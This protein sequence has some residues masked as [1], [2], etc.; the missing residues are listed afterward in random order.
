MKGPPASPTPLVNVTVVRARHSV[1]PASATAHES[2]SGFRNA[3]GR[4]HLPHH[5][6]LR[7]LSLPLEALAVQVG[8]REFVTVAADVNHVSGVA[9]EF[10][11]ALLAR[12]G[13]ADDVVWVEHPAVAADSALPTRS[14]HA[15]PRAA[16]VFNP[17]QGALVQTS[18]G[19]VSLSSAEE[20]YD[21]D[22]T[23]SYRLTEGRLI[24]YPLICR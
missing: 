14:G 13:L 20:P 18:T 10:G 6:L 7:P 17:L 4:L 1:Q 11:S 8:R 23:H 21:S 19:S 5:L 3:S 9:D 22:M 24:R 15:Q 12:L 16:W 2:A